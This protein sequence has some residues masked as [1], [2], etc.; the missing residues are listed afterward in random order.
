MN[1]FIEWF[2]SI[3]PFDWIC[4]KLDKHPRPHS[5]AKEIADLERDARRAMA[6][7]DTEISLI[8]RRRERAQ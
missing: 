7:M 4:N 1:R 2:C 6:K 5:K 3:P 8:R